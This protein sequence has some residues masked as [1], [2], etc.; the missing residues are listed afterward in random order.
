MRFILTCSFPEKEL[1][2]TW[3]TLH[4]DEELP[5]FDTLKSHVSIVVF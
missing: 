4:N 3:T 1:D 2:D 5:D